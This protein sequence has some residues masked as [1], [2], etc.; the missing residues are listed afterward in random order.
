MPIPEEGGPGEQTRAKHSLTT[1]LH[2]I[3]IA[4]QIVGADA[5]HK[6]I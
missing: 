2:L 3:K 4:G 5:Q 6:C 1:A